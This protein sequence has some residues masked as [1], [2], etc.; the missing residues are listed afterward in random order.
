M[1]RIT[2]SIGELA[3]HTGL[4]VKTIRYYSDIGLLPMGE[5][6]SGGHRRYAPEALE[7]LRLVQRLRALDTPIATV[8]EVATGER[9]ISDLV[10]DELNL[11]QRRLTELRW[12]E[13][14]LKALDD[15]S[16]SERLRRLEVLARVQQLPEAHDHLIRSWERTIPSSIP[17][18][19][20]DTITAQAVPDPPADPTAEAVLAYAEL[21]SLTAHPQF[22]LYWECPNVRD[23]A[24][25][26]AELLDA[27]ELA[28]SLVT[29]GVPPQAGAALDHFS[30]ACARSRYE[31]DTPGFRAFMGAQLHSTIPLFQRYWQHVATLSG[32]A[33]PNLG[34]THCWLVEALA[35][36]PGALSGQTAA[37]SGTR[38]DTAP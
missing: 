13:A 18:R 33:G 32:N 20:V 22:P 36:S 30:G 23:K 29:E 31:E 19:L 12:R 25:L 28:D 9:S 37:A 3:R 27:S 38:P 17:A 10:T 21:H 6:S 5:R 16:G 4:S 15:C 34:L 11:V 1:K 8:A 2:W 14:T 35:A 24:S 26:Y 7:Q